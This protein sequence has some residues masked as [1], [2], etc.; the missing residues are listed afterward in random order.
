MFAKEQNAASRICISAR[1][2]APSD[3]HATHDV[4]SFSLA[5]HAP[6]RPFGFEQSIRGGHAESGG[7]IELSLEGLESWK[8]DWRWHVTQAGCA[9][10]IP[11]LERGLASGN[12]EETVN[13]ILEGVRPA[14][15]AIAKP[16][17]MSPLNLVIRFLL[18]LVAL[19]ALGLGGWNLGE[20][21]LGHGPL[22]VFPAI[23]LPVICAAVWGRFRV[24]GDPSSSGRSPVAVR[25]WVRL[26]LEAGFFGSGILVFHGIHWPRLAAVFAAAVLLHYAFSLDRLR[27]LLGKGSHQVHPRA[28]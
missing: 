28:I 21:L 15:G 22:Q 26:L 11:I 19:G 2:V 9:W 3:D 14:G 20:W 24:P 16:W 27:W 6:E 5:L 1:N 8:G 25:G 10:V 18:E 17:R 13:A 4:Y 7:A 23:G 12:A